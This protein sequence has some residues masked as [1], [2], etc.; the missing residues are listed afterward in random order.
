VLID[1]AGDGY[2]LTSVD[3]GVIFDLDCSGIPKRVAWTRPDS[4]DAWLAMDRNG[5]GKID[6]GC[7]LFGNHTPAYAD[8]RDPASENGFVALRLLEGPSYGPSH[9]DGIIDARDAAFGRL[10]LW[11]DANHNGI[12]EP[13][14]LTPVSQT[15]L[16]GI[17]T[18]YKRTRREDRHG[19][20][21]LLRGK[22]YWAGPNGTIETRPVYDVWLR[23]EATDP[24]TSPE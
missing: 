20:A 3:R 8:R 5:N 21:F 10:L 15:D 18:D 22:S 14:E 6:D 4:D 12:S 9:A 17:G 24:G 7:E 23:T 11:R 19:N 13:E 2:A 16:I 1:T